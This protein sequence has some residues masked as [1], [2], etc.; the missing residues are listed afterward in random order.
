MQRVRIA[1]TGHVTPANRAAA[2]DLDLKLGL[3][4]GT[5][6]ARSGVASRAFAGAGETAG[7]LAAAA[8]GRALEA[9][10][11]AVGD[12][13][14]LLYASVMSEQPM[15]STA[16]ALLRRLGGGAGATACFDI[17]AS[18]L[19]FLRG[20]EIAADAIDAGRWRHVGVVAVDVASH[21]LDWTD[22]ET[23]TLFGDGSGAAVLSAAAEGEESAVLGSRSL[24]LPEGFDLC[25][26]KAGGSRHNLHAPPPEPKDG[27]FHMDGHGL[28]RLS[29]E[30]FPAFLTSCLALNGGAVDVIVPHQASV[31]GLKLLRRL[32]SDRGSDGGA[33]EVVDILAEH[34]NQ[35]S[36]SL[37]TALDIAVRDGRIARGRTVLLVG[38]SAGLSMAGLVVRY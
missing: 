37:P 35:V 13:D 21:G 22:L 25:H 1:G 27:Y 4:A 19:G 15:P 7:S 36:A 20:L 17:N 6:M 8:M 11:L 5:T 29:L 12:L 16:V 24:T 38:T 30:R 28:L 10:G 32:V 9:A 26:I 34:G 23:A 31:S 2:A 3:A 18:C 14:A 33:I